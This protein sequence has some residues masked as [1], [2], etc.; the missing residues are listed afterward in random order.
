MDQGLQ[1]GQKAGVGPIGSSK[2]SRING[3]HKTKLKESG[4]VHD[5]YYGQFRVP[6]GVNQVPPAAHGLQQA[7]KARLGLT[8]SLEYSRFNGIH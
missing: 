2:Y 5:I 3:I 8:E 6:A 1:Q 4:G 7:Q